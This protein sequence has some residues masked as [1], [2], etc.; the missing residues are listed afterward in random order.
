MNA[1]MNIQE[2]TAPYMITLQQLGGRRFI[3]MTGAKNLTHDKNGTV[4]CMQIGRNSA[5]VKWVRI[6]LTAD[7]LYTMEFLGEK[8]R[9]FDSQ[10]IEI[11]QYEGVYCDMLQPI[12]TKVTGMYT[13]L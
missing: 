7:D 13:H 2:T 6:T 4:L 10:V 5:K 12:F 11:A 8:G 3:A 1:P 9:G